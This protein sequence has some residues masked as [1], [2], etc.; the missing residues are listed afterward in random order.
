MLVLAGHYEDRVLRLDRFDAGGPTLRVNAGGTLA[1][2]SG[3]ASTLTYERSS[4][5]IIESSARGGRP[6]AI[7]AARAAASRGA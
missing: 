4:F 5:S 2:A 3:L 6:H 7:A 1:F